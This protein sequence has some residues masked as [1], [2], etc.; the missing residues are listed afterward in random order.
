MK[1]KT[2]K[3]LKVG[4]SI[5]LLIVIIAMVIFFISALNVTYAEQNYRGEALGEARNFV[6]IS[7]HI[8]ILLVIPYA[9]IW[10]ILGLCY[11]ILEFIIKP[12]MEEGDLP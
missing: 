12:I 4:M 5:Y 7:A 10:G 2:E 1:K 8:F 11:Y 3:Y 9:I 6:E